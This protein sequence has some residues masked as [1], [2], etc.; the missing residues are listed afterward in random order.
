MIAPERDFG[1]AEPSPVRSTFVPA[2]RYFAIDPK[3]ATLFSALVAAARR[4]GGS[5]IVLEDAERQT[6]S[7]NRLI[8]AAFVLGKKLS[9][10]TAVDHAAGL[11]LPNVNA[12]VVSLFGLN[13][14]GRRVGLLNFTAGSRNLASAV[15]T[16]PLPV[17]ITSRRFVDA[18]KLDD[19][20]A[21]ISATEWTP[22]RKTEIIY[23]E[24]IRK[25]I[26][27]LDKLLGAV[28]ALLPRYFHRRQRMTPDD[29]AVI[30][31][32]SGTEGVPK[33]VALSNANL[34]ANSG[35]IFAHACDFLSP[36]DVAINPLPMFHSFGLTAGT[37]MPLLNGL[38]VAL[39][40]SPLHYKQ[41]PKMIREVEAT[42][43]LSTDTFLQGY[44]R[45]AEPGDLDSLR[46]VVAGAERV[47][48]ATRALL[49]RSGTIV[50]EGYGATECSPVIACNLP[51][52]NRPGTVGRVL[53]GIETRLERVEGIATGGRLFVKGPNVMA[54]YIMPSAPGAV[55][56]PE[57]G[58]HDTG[59]IVEITDGFL[60]IRG[61]AKR[62]AK[63][64]GEMVSLA[65]VE[66]LAARLWPDNTHVVVSLPDPK[67]GESL[68][69]VTDKPDAD[70][71]AL[72]EYARSQSFAELWVPKAILVTAQI[73]VLGS[74]KIDYPQTIEM[75][76]Q[77]RALL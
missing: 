30:L 27:T 37:L 32:T 49:A 33:G 11:M 36:A 17:V 69:L 41:V 28:H 50:L 8:L 61:R 16:G 54:G 64:G 3:A 2:M 34:V 65:A 5:K 12:L 7:Y 23:L 73:P 10:A 35:Q 51:D 63:I 56:P 26:G 22:G 1:S 24:D 71:A 13:A 21:S 67:R 57:G 18:A 47:K 70:K 19:A 42:L 31:F 72:A 6:L 66:A 14:W 68:V 44:A 52:D 58:W 48:D 55:L 46:F 77:A 4:H 74:G 60:S 20:V 45:A 9:D 53:P 59:D 40:P 75:A 62:F 76:R 39:Y 25:E 29:V 43:L 38:K 15:Q